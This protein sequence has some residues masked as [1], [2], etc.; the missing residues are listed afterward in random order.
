[1]HW[2]IDVLCNV[3]L[4]PRL[5]R[6]RYKPNMFSVCSRPPTNANVHN[7]IHLHYSIQIFESNY[8]PRRVM[9]SDNEQE[10]EY[11]Y[12][13]PLTTLQASSNP[14]A[15][16][17]AVNGDLTTSPGFVHF[18]VNIHLDN[19]KIAQQSAMFGILL[20]VL[21][22]VVLVVFTASYSS[23]VNRLVVQPLEKMMTTLR[24][25]AMLMVSVIDYV[26]IV[27]VCMKL[28]LRSLTQSLLFTLIY[29]TSSLPSTHIYTIYIV[30][31]SPHVIP[32]HILHTQTQIN[33]LKDL[34]TANPQE[35]AKEKELAAIK[36]AKIDGESCNCLL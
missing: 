17:W 31:R 28:R 6:C 3:F 9:R 20:I 16:D 14:Y 7:H 27:A 25:S 33:S 29:V 1:M 15:Q 11:S 21:V 13:I 8:H 32:H 18:R 34:E 23:V 10:Y 4:H 30:Q 5:R 26:L 24:T 2:L 22:I 19:T 36:Q 12:D 35:E